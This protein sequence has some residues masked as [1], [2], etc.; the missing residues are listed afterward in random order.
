MSWTESP[1]LVPLITEI[2]GA[3]PGMII[4][5]IGDAAHRDEVSDHN[6]DQ[7]DFVCAADFMIGPRYTR[8]DAETDFDAITDL[9][10]SG[11]KRAAYAILDRRIVSSTVSPGVVRGY[12]GKDPHT[13]H[14]HV[15][16][17]HGA[18]PHPA[19]SWHLYA[20]DDDMT[21]AEFKT[22]MDG[23][24]TGDPAKTGASDKAKAVLSAL[25]WAASFGPD[26]DREKA[27]ERLGHVDT[28]VDEINQKLDAMAPPA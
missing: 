6:P 4:G 14:M 2:R 8:A 3:H 11:D 18:N 24:L 20:K 25:P 9:I 19:T 26:T 7:W 5:T 12:A 22:L 16:V 1:I 28:A 23:Y 21:P 15:S 13:G 27:G 17:P 10:R